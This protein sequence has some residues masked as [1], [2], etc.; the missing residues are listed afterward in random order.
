MPS[1]L[2]A[3]T[4]ALILSSGGVL[5]Q[6]SGGSGGGASTGGTATGSP[7]ASPN[8]APGSASPGNPSMTQ[9]RLG[10]PADPTGTRQ[11][12][13]SGSA[14]SQSG[15]LATPTPSNPQAQRDALGSDSVTKNNA[16]GNAGVDPVVPPTAQEC[17]R[18]WSPDSRWRREELDKYCRR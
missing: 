15:T 7:L 12:N 3:I 2:V 4:V 1:K 9:P 11:Q 13:L 6:S 18:G 8:R 14:S 5:A 16:M 10:P 17:S